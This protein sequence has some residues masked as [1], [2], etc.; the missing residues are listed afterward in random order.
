MGELPG[1]VTTA[2]MSATATPAS[3]TTEVVEVES[4]TAS[5]VASGVVTPGA[6]T[7]WV[8]SW[9][10]PGVG[11]EAVAARPECRGRGVLGVGFLLRLLEDECRPCLEEGWERHLKRQKRAQ[12][13]VS[14]SETAEEREDERLVADRLADVGEGVGKSFE[15]G[16]VI[17]D[18][19]VA[20]RSVAELRLE[21][22]GA[23]LFVVAEKLL[24]GVPDGASGG[25][26][27]HD[28]AE[29]V[30][31]DGTIYPGEHHEFI[32]RLV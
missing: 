14:I 31:G 11:Q 21:L 18:G 13:R 27:P 10:T 17:A 7:S 1:F 25:A 15:L 12:V 2:A 29:Q 6:I 28:D 20:L 19:E 24:D 32:T 23:V 22:D 26:G 3:S 30:D 9:N 16:A 5:A 4:T 8:G